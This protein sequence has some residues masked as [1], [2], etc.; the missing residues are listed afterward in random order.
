MNLVALQE[1]V[2]TSELVDPGEVF[3][4]PP[5]SQTVY[6]TMMQFFQARP[7]TEGEEVLTCSACKRRFVV[8]DV[9]ED[10]AAQRHNKQVHRS[11]ATMVSS[12]EP[13]PQE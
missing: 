4:L 12:L 13:P 6:F 8:H 9:N 3:T 11:Q 7:L 10:L 1:F 2:P 5:K